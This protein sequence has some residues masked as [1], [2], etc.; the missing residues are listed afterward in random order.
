VSAG[1]RNEFARLE[2]ETY[3]TLHA[4]GPQT[5][6]GGEP[7]F[8]ELLL[9]AGLSYDVSDAMTVYAAY[10][11][12]FT[13]PDVGR[14]LRGVSVPDQSVE[15]L[16]SL[17]PIVADNIEVGTSIALGQLRARASY[18]WSESDL[19]QRLVPNADGI[20]TVNRERTEIE[21]LEI[22]L[23][24]EATRWLT[25][26]ANYAALDGRY[27]S[28]GDGRVDRDLDGVNIGPDRLNLYAEVRPTE[29]ASARLQ[30]SVLEDRS[31]DDPGD[32]TDFEGYTL[33]DLLLGYEVGRLG[34]LDL[35]IQNLLDEDY[36][37]YYSQS[38]TTSNARYFAGRGRTVTLRWTG[39]Y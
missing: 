28:N 24:F 11:E 9:N 27:D 16:L 32:A 34:R 26:G 21:G 14:V 18:F 12:G 19:G 31:F 30:A 6:E 1:L 2:V 23:D 29:A 25:L 13:M 38:G 33:V 15:T 39:R 10:A 37:T 7:D 22:A 3:E 20:F 4:Y 5:V 36:I 8:S 35:G 17:E